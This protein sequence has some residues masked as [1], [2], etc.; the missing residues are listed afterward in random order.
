VAG[1]SA[2]G[3]TTLCEGVREEMTFDSDF[4]LT[5]ISLDCFYKGID[6]SVV[7]VKDYNFDHPDAL[8]FDLAYEVHLHAQSRCC[9][10]SSLESQQRSRNTTSALTPGR[11]RP[12]QPCPTPSFSSRGS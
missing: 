11:S 2:A 10:T 4:D 3:K 5:I 7:D 12:R 1:G 9:K 8:D 6:K